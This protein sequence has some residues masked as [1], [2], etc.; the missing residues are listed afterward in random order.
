M[1]NQ[2]DSNIPVLTEVIN[3]EVKTSTLQISPV[4][5]RRVD[6]SRII[7]PPLESTTLPV[8]EIKTINTTPLD[9]IDS[10]EV[11]QVENEEKKWQQLE[12][13]L[14]ENILK[15]VLARTDF[16]LEHKIRDSLA[17]ILENSVDKL[18]EE[19]KLGLKNSIEEVITRAVTQEITKAKMQK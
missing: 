6:A 17:E 12:L 11:D 5:E 13:T 9:S 7:A 8:I 4:H 14:K 3:S 1:S 10:M 16:V 2:F 19:I 15:Q 18:A